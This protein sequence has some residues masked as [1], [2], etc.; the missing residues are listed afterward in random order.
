MSNARF[1][2]IFLILFSIVAIAPRAHADDTTTGWGGMTGNELLPG[3]A[4]SVDLADGKKIA[5]NMRVPALECLSYVGGFMDGYN[6]FGL[7]LRHEKSVCV[8]DK[9]TTGQILRV[10]VK[11]LR[12]HPAELNHSAMYCM[13]AALA[14]SFGCS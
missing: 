5:D 7:I 4:A 10:L 6:I 2:I 1:H 9:V 8:S 3:C 14:D 11:W 12:D 13:S